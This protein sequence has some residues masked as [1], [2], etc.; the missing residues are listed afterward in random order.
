MSSQAGCCISYSIYYQAVHDD[1]G[2][3]TIRISKR[4][5]QDFLTKTWSLNTEMES[6]EMEETHNVFQQKQIIGLIE[7]AG[8][9]VDKWIELSDIRQELDKANGQLL[10]GQ[11]WF[12]KFLLIAT[13]V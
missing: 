2:D 12:R 9:A 6:M 5:L 13:K 3:G 7:Q 10:T 8:F 11:S 1:L 4:C